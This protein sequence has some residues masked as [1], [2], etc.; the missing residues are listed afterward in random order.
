M[1]STVYRLTTMVP[2]KDEK[3]FS[4]FRCI[5]AQVRLYPIVKFIEI[6]ISSLVI[7]MSKLK[8]P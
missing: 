2:E 3:R 4:R 7:E 5:L 8:F 6:V 1:A